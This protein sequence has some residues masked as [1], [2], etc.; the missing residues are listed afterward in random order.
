[1][2]AGLLAQVLPIIILFGLLSVLITIFKTFFLSKF[3]GRLGEASINF[4]AK[5]LLDND[6]YHLTPNVHRFSSAVGG[7]ISGRWS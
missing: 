2:M 6:V 5:R 3:K 1:M 7:S 4:W